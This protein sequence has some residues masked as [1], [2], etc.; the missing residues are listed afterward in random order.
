MLCLTHFLAKLVLSSNKVILDLCKEARL[1]FL[2]VLIVIVGKQGFDLISECAFAFVPWVYD[3]IIP[4]AHII[5]TCFIHEALASFHAPV[6][7]GRAR[8]HS[9]LH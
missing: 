3:L 6:L 5:G 9:S 7:A 4:A 1:S 2:A 8:A